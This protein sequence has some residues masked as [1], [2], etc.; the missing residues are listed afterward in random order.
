M[1]IYPNH[2]ET[3]AVP[4]RRLGRRPRTERPVL[5]YSAIRRA[6]AH[7]VPS[8]TTNLSLFDDWDIRGN[9]QYG[10]CG[11]VSVANSRAL[12]TAGLTSFVQYPT[13]SAILDLYRRSG[14]PNFPQDDN[15][16]DMQQMLDEVRKT[17]IQQPDGTFVKAV[18]FAAL[19]VSNVAELKEAIDVFGFI[20]CGV[21][22]E[23]AQ[24]EQT[25][26]QHPVWD[27]VQ[28][29]DWGGHAVLVGD[30]FETIIDE[31]DCITWAERVGWS[32]AFTRNQLR[33]AYV[34]IWPEHLGSRRFDQAVDLNTLASEYHRLTG[35]TLVLPTP[36]PPAPAPTPPAP[37]PAPT[38]HKV[39]AAVIRE[40]K[41]IAKLVGE[42]VQRLEDL[43][44]R[45]S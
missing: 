3:V 17:G 45:K 6:D 15:G 30:Y 39:L 2:V 18:A 22:L 4:G 38:E 33:E 21:D 11:P 16:V 7:V 8:T 36:T 44:N 25:D 12:I 37:S 43:E 40:L 42:A 1:D 41:A 24:Q 27:Y 31:F 29:P 34:V 10:D 9:D 5:R 32:D 20:L 19:D 28:S 35:Q 26:L 14:N 23:Q 13:L